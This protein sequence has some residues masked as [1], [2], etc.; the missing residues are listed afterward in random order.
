MVRTI[1]AV[2]VWLS[3]VCGAPAWAANDEWA[4]QVVHRQ[5]QKYYA[6]W[7]QEPDQTKQGLVPAPPPL[8]TGFSI[9]EWSV[10]PKQASLL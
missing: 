9:A 5:L 2:A 8:L 10:E 7:F 3:L 1:A 4:K 6:E